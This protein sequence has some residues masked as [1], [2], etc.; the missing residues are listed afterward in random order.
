MTR[1]S[2]FR[3]RRLAAWVLLAV[4]VAGCGDREA[5]DH[6][7]PDAHGDELPALAPVPLDEGERLRVVATTSIVGDVVQQVGGEEIDLTVLLPL[8][9]DPHAF[10]PAPQDAA[11]VADAHVVF[12]N[13]AGMEVFLDSLLESAGEGVTVISVSSG[14]ELLSLEGDVHEED[15]HQHG[16]DDPHVWFDPHNVMVWAD[17]I[18]Q[19]LGALDPEN[20]GS[21]QANGAAYVA[22]LEALDLWIEEQVA[23]VDPDKRLL[24]TDHASFGYFARRYGFEQVG[25]LFPGYST[26]A[27]PSARDLAELES[28]IASLGVEAVF[29]GLTVNPDLAERVAEDTGTQLLFLYTG[30]LGE[31]GGPAGDYISFMQ[32]NVTTIVSALR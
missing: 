5:S 28:A 2:G 10:D 29:V 6:D 15:D 19:V 20:A 16:G 11:A 7:H 14:I 22:E 31:P 30:S 25:A 24:V 12:I 1:E 32:Y 4:I 27:E 21:Y 13:G 8:G 18:E 17:N 9:T 3:V 26:L 23:Q